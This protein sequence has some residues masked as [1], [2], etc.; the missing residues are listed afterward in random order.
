MDLIVSRENKN[1]KELAA[2]LSG[3]KHRDLSGLFALEGLRL[4]LDALESGVRIETLFLTEEAD[5]RYPQLERLKKNTGR[6]LWLG[7]DLARRIADTKT[8]QGVFCI[9]KK[10]DN[11]ESAVK[12]ERSGKYLL[13]SG[14]QDPGNLGAILRTAQALGVDGVFACDC[15]DLYS[16]KVLRAAMG[17]LFRLPVAVCGD[18]AEM[19]ARL[20]KARIPVYAAALAGGATRLDRL[21]FSAGCAVLVGNEGNGLPPGLV[22]QCDG[23]VIIPMREDAN[24][25]NA[26]T[27]AAIILWEMTKVRLETTNQKTGGC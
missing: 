1:V 11:S 21:D 15:P 13:L 7:A 27:A 8:P 19:V 12:M 3:K 14:L 5:K 6:T 18:S 23:S 24:S 10:L 2:L 17:G 25:L 9:C 20:Q 4:C 26:A 16:P 22:E